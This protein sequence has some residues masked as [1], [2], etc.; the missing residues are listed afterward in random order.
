MSE[1]NLEQ[2][3]Q[4]LRKSPDLKKLGA[5]MENAHQLAT[6]TPPDF[7]KALGFETAAATTL[8]A[9]KPNLMKWLRFTKQYMRDKGTHEFSNVEVHS[10][11]SL[12][13]NC[14]ASSSSN[15]WVMV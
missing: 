2:L 1:L 12:E 6:R 7:F 5:D 10:R 9:D 14:S 8:S 4:S 13:T 11:K 3:F 15:G